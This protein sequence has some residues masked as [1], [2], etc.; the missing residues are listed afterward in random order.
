MSDG[1]PGGA[2]DTAVGMFWIGLV[3]AALFWLFWTFQGDLIMSTFRWIRYG[4]LWLVMQILGEDHTY[5]IRGEDVPIGGLLEYAEEAPASRI[6]LDFLGL[7]STATMLSYRWLFL[8]IMCG[9]ALW[10]Y[11]RGP[12]SEN[13][14][15]FS[16]NT[17]IK[18]QAK[19]FPV[20]EPFVKFNPTKLPPRPPGSPVPA[21]IQMF[22]E[23]LGPEEWL[24]Y[25][26]LTPNS[27]G[28]LNEAALERAFAKQLGP[29]WK[30]AKALAPHKQ[31]LLASFA[32]KA[33]R[34][35]NEAD[36]ML[37]RLARCWSHDKGLSLNKDRKLLGEARKVLRDKNLSQKTLSFCNQHGWQTTALMRALWYA[38]SEGGVMA[39]GMFVWLR[40]Y[41]RQLWY[42]LNNL[43][44]NSYHLEALGAICHYKAEKIA[45]RPIPKPKVKD[46]I[47]SISEYMDSDMA[48][49]IPQ[50]DYSGSQK[51]GVKKM[52][53]A[54]A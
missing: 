25:H 41:D 6:S 23:A 32:L 47:Q 27:E 3:L 54:K 34:K 13:R 21:E 37:G 39:P 48:R 9:V 12:E 49:P 35:R 43:G 8:I 40:G 22:S 10:A 36:D 7:L 11:F 38:R 2:S 14:I 4:E 15:K 33:S 45:Q 44:R 5:F 50:K 53:K 52:K 20:I 29:R 18:R 16:L 42:P 24:A 46:A 51:R 30:G 26:D 19:N 1:K 17:L 28:K 31:I